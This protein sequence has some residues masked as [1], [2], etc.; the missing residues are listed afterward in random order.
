L[1]MD[2]DVWELPYS[3]ILNHTVE[4]VILNAKNAKNDQIKI[5]RLV[6]VVLEELKLKKDEHNA[7]FFLPKKMKFSEFLENSDFVFLALHGGDGENGNI[8]KTLTKAGVKYNGSDEKVSQLCMDKFATGEF[9][10]ESNIKGLTI[11]SQKV[12]PFNETKNY[13]DS[14]MLWDKLT[15]ELNAKTLIVKPKDDG[16]STG[17]AHLY[18]HTDLSEYMKHMVR[19]DAQIPAGTLK[20][21]DT[22]LEMPGAALKD[23]L[24]EK[25]IETDN[26]QVKGN[27]LK[28]HRVSGM[29]EV[30]IGV[31]E[32]Y[33]ILNNKKNKK[34]HAF[35]PSITIV[36]GEVL[37]VEEKFQ[38]G[39]GVNL[40]PPPKEIVS[41]KAI[42]NAKKILEELVEK[43]G[44]KGYARV[45]AFM[46]VKTGDLR[47]IELNTLPGLTPSTVL[48]HQALS[49][50]PQIFPKELLER[51]IH[52]AG[53]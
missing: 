31:L 2:G 42:A 36:E 51:I 32:T 52:S 39:T 16:C 48:Y 49:E 30:T 11:A 35:N 13:L 33:T 29:V 43:V 44:I 20:N 14:T 6:K 46:D 5:E 50:D 1:D 10:R 45:D 8:Q 21:Q 26:V 18:S 17:I 34:L 25:F 27:K 41:L 40:T 22:I 7:P 3:L 24:F 37:S 15:R 38:G 53:Y 47:V 23:V 28:Y 9:I 12:L 4:E 19:C